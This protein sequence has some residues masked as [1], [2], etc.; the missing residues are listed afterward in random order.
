MKNKLKGHTVYLSQKHESAKPSW[1]AKLWLYYVGDATG[2]GVIAI[3]PSHFSISL[4]ILKFCNSQE[5]RVVHL[6]KLSDVAFG[7]SASASTRAA[8]L[9]STPCD[10]FLF[11]SNCHCT[12]TFSLGSCDTS[13]C[14]SLIRLETSTHVH[15]YID[16]SNIN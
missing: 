3:G 10:H 15:S 11:P 6:P 7:T 4:Q 2:A 9:R 12:T 13:I 5:C 16:I 14:F 8:R 1:N